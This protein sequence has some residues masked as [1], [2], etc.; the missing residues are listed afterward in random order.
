MT[1]AL[2]SED[3]LRRRYAPPLPLIERKQLA[4]L[5]RHCRRF[6]ARAP[7][8]MIATSGPDG[9]CD[10]SP[11]GDAPGFVRVLDD[12]RLAIPDRKGN[13]RIDSLRNVVVNAHAGLLFVVPGVDDT[14]RVNGRA[15]I[16]ADESLLAAMAVAG[17]QPAS[18]LVLEVE[19]AYLHCGRAFK[20]GQVWNPRTFAARG[21]LPT[22]A[23]MLAEQTDPDADEQRLLDE[24][25][26]ES[27]W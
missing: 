23:E 18:A 17:K 5:D 8:V 15:S 24:S 19:E 27:L 12:M 11:R 6:I 3:E 7:L 4:R 22:L 9:S 26:R 2:T 14:L 21:E 16:V 13:N 25:G 20:R 10:V 1:G